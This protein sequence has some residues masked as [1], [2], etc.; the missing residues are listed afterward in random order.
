MSHEQR[1]EL[2]AARRIAEAV[3]AVVN[4]TP[5][6]APG[7]LLYAALME[8]GMSLN[9]FEMLMSVLVEAKRISKRGDLY[10]RLAEHGQVQ[11]RAGAAGKGSSGQMITPDDPPGEPQQRQR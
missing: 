9:D 5:T 3:I 6:G 8:H 7:G 2:I 10:Q 11:R 1:N 4:E